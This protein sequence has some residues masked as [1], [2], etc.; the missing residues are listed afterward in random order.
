MRHDIGWAV[1]L[2]TWWRRVRAMLPIPLPA[3]HAAQRAEG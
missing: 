3:A 1:T 2:M